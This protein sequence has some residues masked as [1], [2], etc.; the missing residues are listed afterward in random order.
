ML[1]RC[2]MDGILQTHVRI[3]LSTEGFYDAS[4][5]NQIKCDY[6]QDDVS[7]RYVHREPR[8]YASIGY[9]G[10]VWDVPVLL[11]EERPITNYRA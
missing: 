10:T 2:V 6:V 5:P 9:N 3:P 8:F 1:I 7:M 11:K 4:N